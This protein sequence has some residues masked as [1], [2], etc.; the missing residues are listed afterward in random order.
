MA[1]RMPTTPT[2]QYAAPERGDIGIAFEKGTKSLFGSAGITFSGMGGDFLKTVGLQEMGQNW[3]GDAYASGILMGMDMNELDE[4]LKGPRT[5]RDID[6]WKGAVAWGLNSVSEQIPTL[7]AQFGPALAAAA[8]T[9]GLGG[10]PARAGMAAT[11]TALGTIDFMNTAEVYSQLLMET[12]ESRPAVA[13]GTGAAM[14]VLD[15]LL[16]LRVI[17][18]MGMGRGFAGYFGKELKNPDKKFRTLLGGALEGAVTEG[19]TEY[20]QTVF[21]NMALQYVKAEDALPEFSEEMMLEQEEAG[22]RGALIGGL[23]G[24]PIAYGGLRRAAQ[25]KAKAL[26]ELGK[27]AEENNAPDTPLPT[28]DTV[29]FRSVL[30]GALNTKIEGQL[31][32]LSPE[33]MTAEWFSPRA[34]QARATEE[35]LRTMGEFGATGEEQLGPRSPSYLQSLYGAYLNGRMEKQLSD[36]EKTE[37]GQIVRRAGQLA[38]PSFIPG[39]GMTAPYE[40]TIS[41]MGTPDASWGK[42]RILPKKVWNETL[43]EWVTPP[44]TDEQLRRIE[45][46]EDATFEGTIPDVIDLDKDLIVTDDWGGIPVGKVGKWAEMGW[47]PIGK[48]PI[49]NLSNGAPSMKTNPKTGKLEPTYHLIHTNGEV[50]I[51]RES[52]NKESDWIVTD[53]ESDKIIDRGR[54]IAPLKKKYAVAPLTQAQGAEEAQETLGQEKEDALRA[55][56]AQ[57]LTATGKM[58]LSRG[59]KVR[60]WRNNE[61]G[62]EVFTILNITAAQNPAPGMYDAEKPVRQRRI[63]ATREKYEEKIKVRDVYHLKD[64]RTGDEAKIVLPDEGQT[65][66]DATWRLVAVRPIGEVQPE[67]TDRVTRADIAYADPII[68]DDELYEYTEKGDRIKIA[69]DRGVNLKAFEKL[70]QDKKYRGNFENALANASIVRGERISAN[71]K[72]YSA[73]AKEA[74]DKFIKDS[75]KTREE[76]GIPY[77]RAVEEENRILDWAI[78]KQK[79]VQLEGS[80]EDSIKEAAQLNFEQ[81]SEEARSEYGLDVLRGPTEEEI[82][83]LVGPD[84]EIA[85]ARLAAGVDKGEAIEGEVSPI[86]PTITKKEPRKKR[87][88][89][90]QDPLFTKMLREYAVDKGTT[91]DKL[92]SEE[93]AD[94]QSI[95][96]PEDKPIGGYKV[97]TKREIGEDTRKSQVSVAKGQV[98]TR[99][100]GLGAA[101]ARRE[102]DRLTAEA[103]AKGIKVVQPEGH[104]KD[105]SLLD[106]RDPDTQVLPSPETHHV[107]IAPEVA[108]RVGINPAFFHRYET[109]PAEVS[110]ILSAG[111]APEGYIKILGH[112]ISKMDVVGVEELTGEAPTLSVDSFIRV[113]SPE[114]EQVFKR[115]RFSQSLTGRKRAYEAAEAGVEALVSV[116]ESIPGHETISAAWVDPVTGGVIVQRE[117]E[118]S[119]REQMREV[120]IRELTGAWRGPIKGPPIPRFDPDY[121]RTYEVYLT[122]ESREEHE[123]MLKELKNRLLNIE[124]VVTERGPMKYEEGREARPKKLK[125]TTLYLHDLTKDKKLLGK[126]LDAWSRDKQV[127]VQLEPSMV[128][129]I[130]RERKRDKLPALP[131]DTKFRVYRA[132]HETDEGIIGLHT[133]E[134]QRPPLTGKENR[135]LVSYL[136]Y[137]REV[138][139]KKATKAFV[140]GKIEERIGGLTEYETLVSKGPAQ[141]ARLVASF[142]TNLKG[143][144]AEMEKFF[145]DMFIPQ[146]HAFGRWGEKRDVFLSKRAKELKEQKG[147]T[148]LVSFFDGGTMEGRIGKVRQ[149]AGTFELITTKEEWKRELP[150]EMD[151][152]GYDAIQ[153]DVPAAPKRKIPEIE[154]APGGYLDVLDIGHRVRPMVFKG[155]GVVDRTPWTVSHLAPPTG[156][157]RLEVIKTPSPSGKRGTEKYTII[158]DGITETNALGADKFGVKQTVAFINKLSKET[159]RGEG[160]DIVSLPEEIAAQNR[161]WRVG[162]QGEVVTSY[163]GRTINFA[164]T[165]YVAPPLAGKVSLGW[166][167]GSSVYDDINKN[168]DENNKKTEAQLKVLKDA[169]AKTNAA[170]EIMGPPAPV[171][172]PAEVK[173]DVVVPAETHVVNEGK[174]LRDLKKAEDSDVW[175]DYV[176]KYPFLLDYDPDTNR[177]EFDLRNWS[178]EETPEGLRFARRERPLTDAEFKEAAGAIATAPEV[179]PE[180]TTP[181]PEVTPEVTPPPVSVD[182]G[183]TTKEAIL[184]YATRYLNDDKTPAEEGELGVT[185]GEDMFVMAS[186][187]G[188]TKKEIDTA[189]NLLDEGSTRGLLGFQEHTVAEMIRDVIA[190][191]RGVKPYQYG[192]VME[193]DQRVWKGQ[194]S[195]IPQDSKWGRGGWIEGVLV[196][197]G[198]VLR[199]STPS[200]KAQATKRANEAAR[201]KEYTDLEKDLRQGV[202][203]DTG[204]EQAAAAIEKRLQQTGTRDTSR[205]ITDEKGNV[206]F[207]GYTF[208]KNP[209][210]SA[211][212]IAKETDTNDKVLTEKEVKN[213]TLLELPLNQKFKDKFGGEWQKIQQVGDNRSLLKFI[214]GTKPN[215]SFQIEAEGKKG[216]IDFQPNMTIEADSWSTPSDLYLLPVELSGVPGK[217]G[218][219]GEK[220]S[221]DNVITNFSVVQPL[222]TSDS[223]GRITYNTGLTPKEF[224]EEVAKRTG[225]LNLA[226]LEKQGAIRIVQN[227]QD[228]PD[229]PQGLAV[230]AV[231]RNGQAWFI[232]NNIKK[233]EIGG[234]FAHE[235]GVH[236]GAKN[237]YGQEEWN[238]I[239]ASARSLRESSD[240]W[241]NSFR[242]AAALF[243]F[244]SAAPTSLSEAASKKWNPYTK[245]EAQSFIEE[246]AIGYY[247]EAVDPYRGRKEGIVDDMWRTLM[248]LAL[249]VRAR[250]RRWLGNIVG[251][252]TKLSEKELLAFIRGGIRG[253]HNRNVEQA[254]IRSTE[255]Y[256][257]IFDSEAG[258]ALDQKAIDTANAVLN[259]YTS[260]KALEN[261]SLV[262]AI[263]DKILK[264]FYP[265]K[266]LSYSGMYKMGRSETEGLKGEKEKIGQEILKTYENISKEENDQAVEYLTTPDADSMI[267]KSKRIRDAT[268]KYKRLINDLGEQA[269]AM[270]LIPEEELIKDAY[271]PRI[272]LMNL[273]STKNPTSSP[274][275]RKPSQLHWTKERIDMYEEMREM[276]GEITD[277]RYLVYKAYTIPAQDMVLLD[278][279]Q[280]ISQEKAFEEGKAPWVLP[281]QWIAYKVTD[282][283]TGK[284]LTKRRTVAAIRREIQGLKRVSDYPATSERVRENIAAHIGELETQVKKFYVKIGAPPNPTPEQVNDAIQKYHSK[285]YDPTSFRPIPEDDRFGP[286]S[287]AWVRKEIYDDILG[288]AD[289]AFGEANPWNP[290]GTHTRM[291]RWVSIFKLLKVPLNPPSAARNMVT[292]TVN[293]QLLG[294]M[295]FSAQPSRLRA[296]FLA[297]YR[298]IDDG[299]KFGNLG[300]DGKGLTAHQIANKYGISG[301]TLVS[302]ELRQLEEVF[303][304][305]E[306]EGVFSLT[307]KFGEWARK[308]GK[309]GAEIYQML[310]VMG[311]TALIQYN[312]EHKQHILEEIRNLPENLGPDGKPVI[313]LEY[314]A[315]LEAN[316]VLFDYSEVSPIVRGLRSSFFGAPFI[317]FQVKVL[318]ELLKVVARYPWRFW[319]YVSLYAGAQALF[320]SNPFEDDEWEKVIRLAPEWI[321]ERGSG[322]IMPFRDEHG[323]LQ[324]ADL[325]YFF[326]WSGIT[327][328]VGGLVKGEWGQA[329]REAGLVAPGWQVANALLSNKDTFTGREIIDE[330]DSAFDRGY[331]TLSY[332]WQMSMPNVLT[333][334]GFINMPSLVKAVARMD[335]SELEG[336]IFDATMGRTNR[337][338][339]P[340]RDVTAAAL[341]LVGLNLTPIPPGARGVQIK[342]H[343]AQERRLKAEITSVRDDRS[344]SKKQRDRQVNH[345]RRKVDEAREERRKF[346]EE[347]AGVGA[348]L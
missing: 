136:G 289:V 224:R 301:T 285:E 298:G 229:P 36:V 244:V 315:V 94:A 254:S 53:N 103:E 161:A 86:P 255:N 145:H 105:A 339:E 51:K 262:R 222:P 332:A 291:A 101:E 54:T 194:M 135:I 84:L 132:F 337:Y 130:N 7:M 16:P 192:E 246:E 79:G 187:P 310:E 155:E 197:Q 211:T 166:E 45:Y 144:V 70:M 93:I 242:L 309:T 329:A 42:R 343:I 87:L 80:L 123:V 198:L 196:S 282:P 195:G 269:V 14:S 292:N 237:I 223:R 311:K 120:P 214:G 27:V 317:T 230:R 127:E 189:Y 150:I 251:V 167:V 253:A 110:Y 12:G 114:N 61:P 312:L 83:R 21:E 188:V 175:V 338:G 19:S 11:A 122:W 260:E 13:A 117:T 276:K 38:I 100:K 234:V 342:R 294:G 321:R 174:M 252:E 193:G 62:D 69:R 41:G 176:E 134:E 49:L 157:V 346:S 210:A 111:Q 258:L 313:T 284:T 228:V 340:K 341:S 107:K 60:L 129:T 168:I 5:V 270:G 10:T 102:Q 300:P 225:K 99:L 116:P 115:G 108:K 306:K 104:P 33:Y 257:A 323:R 347:T 206:I 65:W 325:S 95:N 328:T 31:P 235:L 171:T 20:L 233:E 226:R 35:H 66:K 184:E 241:R 220:I 139:I 88:V 149:E 58:P 331:A 216:T 44:L 112:H 148:A 92:S 180:D 322:F 265:L 18:R 124:R 119:V 91:L 344:L 296:A 202:P 126:N 57:H 133:I 52:T 271:L 334:R 277:V 264:F 37:F 97:S 28:L 248:D 212:R 333:R 76:L 34:R 267:I 221:V 1:I 268:V 81:M 320:G 113:D 141:G 153:F 239:L 273:L 250:M 146:T 247:T 204:K 178:I 154:M 314:A 29:K 98:T 15:M 297:E 165:D 335:S 22:A 6:D 73:R 63:L 275:G 308:I 158:V 286:L 326:P 279:L 219:T 293:L 316:R 163:A 281:T 50:T 2:L 142:N 71:V 191:Q 181:P 169:F 140:R 147:V 4:Q 205:D 67:Y 17:N 159:D 232:T 131:V 55:A 125:R 236:V 307:H 203:D 290:F 89:W 23:L 25:A 348:A 318:P 302:A 227:Q 177:Y 185:I 59:D 85:G 299:P 48:T 266:P 3:I 143:D 256:S 39:R 278:F 209:P 190:V 345:L 82:E 305:A 199:E 9:R 90:R 200:E 173:P 213:K 162:P 68:Q 272:F 287:G 182:E 280:G 259:R 263:K 330:N 215:L 179:T 109:S 238:Y 303:R 138:P 118:S 245:Q 74:I 240:E 243:N 172:E 249:R 186:I 170:P 56:Y 128:R 106:V 121:N 283:K 336:K 96:W 164:R 231:E 295:P 75:A 218:T 32:G 40:G 46:G 207:E 26:S 201:R 72:R 208:Q 77:N 304:R 30:K 8:L 183:D 137:T 274:W 217:G 156:L 43:G 78:E 47:W 319:P 288:N 151:I 324:V 152:L 24:I 160:L 261:V 327:Q 64:D